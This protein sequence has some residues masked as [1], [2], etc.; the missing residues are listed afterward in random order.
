MIECSDK[1]TV[2]RF[3]EFE[4]R[5]ADSAMKISTD[6]VILGAW[7]DVKGVRTAIDAGSGTGLLSLMLAQRGVSKILGVELEKR[8][9]NESLYNRE[10]SLW[11]AAICFI[12]DDISNLELP[13]VDLVISNPPY[14]DYGRSAIVSPRESKKLARHE[15]SLSYSWLL[16]NARNILDPAIGRLSFIS[17]AERE[18]EIQFLSRLHSLHLSRKVFV[19]SS[20]KKRTARILWDFR[21]HDSVLKEGEL[22]IHDESGDYTQSYIN[23]TKDFYVKF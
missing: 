18:E 20:P 7:V 14:F 9:Y 23:L 11:N 16:E 22:F 21:L 1:K 2:F 15:A 12:N 5:N 6:S 3:K 4:M 13:Q 19:Y 10:H 8:A 17:P